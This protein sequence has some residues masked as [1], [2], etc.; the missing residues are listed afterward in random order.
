[1][2]Y[3]GL[4]GSLEFLDCIYYLL[5]DIYINIYKTLYINAKCESLN[6][7]SKVGPNV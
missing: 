6:G 3:I 2:K 7:I 5:Y 1:M 4:R